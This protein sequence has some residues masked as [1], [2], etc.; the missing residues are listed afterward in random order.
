MTTGGLDTAD[1]MESGSAAGAANRLDPK[2]LVIVALL[3]SSTLNVGGVVDDA[4]S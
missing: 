4:A 2:G 1:A 3:V